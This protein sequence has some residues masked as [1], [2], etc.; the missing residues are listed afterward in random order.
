M[1]AITFSLTAANPFP[2]LTVTL[3]TATS[4]LILV[5]KHK[6]LLLSFQ[7]PF[8][9]SLLPGISLTTLPDLFAFPLKLAFFHL[10]GVCSLHRK[11]SF[12]SFNSSSRDLFCWGLIRGKY[13]KD[14]DMHNY[15]KGVQ[16]HFLS[17][18]SIKLVLESIKHL[19]I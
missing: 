16:C 5:Y 7:V 14:S 4:T 12:C 8:S 13:N 10:A 18:L 11:A 17:R 1:I 3:S 19:P 15:R 9:L 6:Q 2:S